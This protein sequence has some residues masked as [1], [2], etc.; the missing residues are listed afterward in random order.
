MVNG[1]PT[2][3]VFAVGPKVSPLGWKKYR[4]NSQNIKIWCKQ[5]ISTCTIICLAVTDSPQ[6]ILVS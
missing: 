3:N 2:M 1:H 4:Q 6:A 5:G